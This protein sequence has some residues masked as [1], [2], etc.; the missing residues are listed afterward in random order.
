MPMVNGDNSRIYPINKL[1]A[2]VD[3]LASEGIST[4]LALRDTGVRPQDLK[5]PTARISIRQLL[6]A[7]R[8][9]L[10]FSRDPAFAIRLGQSIQVTTYGM[11]GYALLSTPDQR[12]LIDLVVKYHRLMLAT[13]DLSFREEAGTEVGIWT[14]EPLAR[15]TEEPRLYRFIVEL[16][17]GT[18]TTLSGDILGRPEIKKEIRVTYPCSPDIPAYDEL[19]RCPV[20]FGQD[21]NELR[22]NTTW[23]DERA[24]RY[25]ELTF[26]TMQN[27]C[28]DMLAQMGSNA[29]VARQVQQV[30][31]ESPGRLLTIEAVCQRLKLS[32]RTLR[33]KLNA[34]GT[35]YGAL[36]QETR[37]RL[38]KRYLRETVMSVEEIAN[39]IGYRDV[40][41]FRR[42][43]QRATQVTPAAYRRAQ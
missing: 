11:Y 8:N 33:R 17:L 4:E 7:Y 28:A 3:A 34:E 19:F 20:H 12:S 26:L 31:L 40:S 30:L 21:R 14:I 2:V 25:N 41:N 16:Y 13:A 27:V 37:V 36:V 23:M 10:A 29:A 38:A 32:A 6:A 43:F 42:A 1:V 24:R 18:V 5:S 15:A 9:A 22:V 35:S 39:R